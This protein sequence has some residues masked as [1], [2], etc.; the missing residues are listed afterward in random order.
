MLSKL[1]VHTKRM[2]RKGRGDH[3]PIADE[4]EGVI[5]DGA[6][7]HR[8]DGR[9]D[10]HMSS[11]QSRR[12]MIIGQGVRWSSRG[13]T[14]CAELEAVWCDESERNGGAAGGHSEASEHRLTSVC[15]SLSPY[16]AVY[17]KCESLERPRGTGIM[18]EDM[19]S[20]WNY[21]QAFPG[22]LLFRTHVR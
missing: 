9:R 15:H 5:V 22:R 4:G 1:H 3:I 19:Q 7:S 21:L 11:G 8:S 10:R 6:I 16:L 2:G 14:R 18:D 12:R 13:T 20:I 17:I